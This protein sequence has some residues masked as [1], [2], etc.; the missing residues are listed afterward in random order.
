MLAMR[1]ACRSRW[2]TPA[3]GAFYT[4][5]LVYVTNVTLLEGAVPITATAVLFGLVI[6]AGACSI[7]GNTRAA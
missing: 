7:L 5:M 6:V 4:G 2:A 3:L 1:D